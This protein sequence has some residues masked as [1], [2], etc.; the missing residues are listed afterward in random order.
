MFVKDLTVLKSRFILKNLLIII[1]LLIFLTS[2]SFSKWEQCFGEGYSI[3]YV[4]TIN[5]FGSDIFVGTDKGIFLS[6]DNGDSWISRDSGMNGL[7]SYTFAKSDSNIFAGTEKGIYLSTN[8]GYSWNRINTGFEN[9]L[10]TDI[11][12]NR[13]NIFVAN[14]G[15]GVL[16]STDNGLSWIEKNEGITPSELFINSIAIND[17]NIFGGSCR[18]GVYL[19]KDFGNSWIKKNNGITNINVHSIIPNGENIFLAT[20]GGIFISSNNGDAW[21]NK[22][23]GNIY[24]MDIIGSYI[25]AGNEFG[26]YLSKDS[27]NN[28]AWDTL[29]LLRVTSIT[30]GDSLIFI[31]AER[32]IYRAKLSDFGITGVEDGD[33]SEDSIKIFPNP[34]CDFIEINV[35]NRQACSLQREIKIYNTIGEC[36]MHLTPTLS[37]GEGARIDVSGLP[38]GIYFVRVGDRV[39][40]IIKI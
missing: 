17:S 18:E 26:V 21:I 25:F 4:F 32:G 14:W 16:L 11:V 24:S 38:P 1:I 9:Y 27:G 23:E 13:S 10:V 2:T 35:G 19:S 33:R 29:G 3:G 12:V 30:I 39:S 6:T 7:N 34:A 20:N 36:V 8:N 28:W 40:K 5:I 37:E 31:G 22:T 15:Q